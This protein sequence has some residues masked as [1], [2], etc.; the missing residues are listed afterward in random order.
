MSLL[1][2]DK[3]QTRYRLLQPRMELLCTSVLDKLIKGSEKWLRSLYDWT[4]HSKEAFLKDNLSILI[5]QAV[6]VQHEAL[7]SSFGELVRV[8][9]SVVCVHQVDHILPTLFM[10]EDAETFEKSMKFLLN[11]VAQVDGSDAKPKALGLPT[12][13]TLSLQSL[14]C[15]LSI[16]LGHEKPERR[17]RTM[18]VIM[19]V[20]GY[21]WENEVS[22][23]QPRHNSP[24][25]RRSL[26]TFLCL[27]IL[28][29]M[30]DISNA[31]KD[32]NRA[33]TLTVKA[34]HLRSL[35]GLV[36]LLQPIPNSVMSQVRK[37]ICSKW[38]LIGTEH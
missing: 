10:E 7:L 18:E 22:E 26:S 3:G 4:N 13:T 21:A 2:E 23:Q 35:E 6:L 24:V 33:M 19:M 14:L 32:S 1:A 17:K 34:R 8:P 9:A 11:L 31:I 20:E 36:T 15:Q 12:L 28:G 29:I 38:L 30:S 16:E 37:I 27:H 5:P 25:E